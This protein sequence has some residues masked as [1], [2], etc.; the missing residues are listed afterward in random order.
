MAG[1]ADREC[2]TSR[3]RGVSFPS[4]CSEPPELGDRDLSTGRRNG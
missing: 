2:A 4:S 1:N 3:S